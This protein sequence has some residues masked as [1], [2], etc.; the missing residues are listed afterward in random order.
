MNDSIQ[1]PIRLQPDF[2]YE[3]CTQN[4]YICGMYEMDLN[5]KILNNKISMFILKKNY[6]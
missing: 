2:E 3:N 5:L 4:Y 6:Q 1:K